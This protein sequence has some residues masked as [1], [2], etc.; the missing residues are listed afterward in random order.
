MYVYIYIYIIKYPNQPGPWSGVDCC[1]QAGRG[2]HIFINIKHT[3]I[4]GHIYIYHVFT[5]VYMFI[6][7]YIYIDIK[8]NTQTNP[9]HGPGWI[10]AARLE[11]VHIYLYI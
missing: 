1:G 6:Y 11:E 3:Y 9:G 10:A 7:M 2:A 5:S 8:L 4:H